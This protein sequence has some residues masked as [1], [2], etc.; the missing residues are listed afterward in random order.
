MDDGDYIQLLEG[1]VRD[2][3]RTVIDLEI[4][5]DKITDAVER[6]IERLHAELDHS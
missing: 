6:I 2:L 5:M 1:K 4:R 3:E